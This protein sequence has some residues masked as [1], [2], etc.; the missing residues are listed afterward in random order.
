MN[1]DRPDPQ[2]RLLLL[3]ALVVSTP[4]SAPRSDAAPQPTAMPRTWQFEF[5]STPPES[6]AIPDGE[7]N[8]S[9]YWYMPYRVM[10]TS[11]RDRALLPVIT[12]ATDQG[13]IIRANRNISPSVFTAIRIE[14]QMPLLQNPI[15]MSRRLKRGRDH[16]RHSVAIW[17]AFEGDVDQFSVF[18]TGLSGEHTTVLDPATGEPVIDPASLEPVIDP[19]TNEPKI[20]TST[21]E[22]VIEP[23]PLLLRKTFMLDYELAGTTDH[24]QR[25]SP[26]R[27]GRHWVMR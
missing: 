25:L 7:G 26:V 21:G 13:D 23:R 20:D 9:W 19:R 5:A 1:A 11:K 16:M 8:Y 24:P 27:A 17:P 10:N 4:F 12:I 14:M 2:P 3:V 15:T 18:V 6:I 22:P